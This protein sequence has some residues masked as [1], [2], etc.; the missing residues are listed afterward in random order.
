MKKKR[1]SNS[2]WAVPILLCLCCSAQEKITVNRK[3]YC[4][5]SNHP[6]HPTQCYAYGETTGAIWYMACE[7]NKKDDNH[8]HPLEIGTYDYD[9]MQTDTVCDSQWASGCIKRKRML[10]NLHCAHLVIY[11]ITE[12]NLK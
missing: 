10:I 8:C 7:T 11:S 3:G 6:D 5:P 9:V 2:V 4:G 12:T 1:I